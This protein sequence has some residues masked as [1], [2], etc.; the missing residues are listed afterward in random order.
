M[1]LKAVQHLQP[2]RPEETGQKLP[3][4]PNNLQNSARSSSTTTK[5]GQPATPTNKHVKDAPTSSDT[6]TNGA[7]HNLQ[8]RLEGHVP[9]IRIYSSIYA[10]QGGTNGCYR[11]PHGD[12]CSQDLQEETST[13]T[14]QSS[15]SISSSITINTTNSCPSGSTGDNT[16]ISEHRTKEGSP[17]ANAQS[18]QTAA[19]PITTGNQNNTAASQP[20]EGEH[21]QAIKILKWNCCSIRNKLHL[22]MADAFVHRRDVILLQETRLP[23][24]RNVRF[25]GYSAYHLPAIEGQTVGCSVLVKNSIPSKRIEHPIHCGDGT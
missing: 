18:E 8:K 20:D 17:R 6:T 21:D 19:P 4:T 23:E 9:H 7:P 24:D 15:Q 3:P 16:G 1:S 10:G 2:P 13:P 22:L 25:P 14:T 5:D 11:F 12:S